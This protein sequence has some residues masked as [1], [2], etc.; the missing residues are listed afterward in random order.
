MR[1]AL[2]AHFWG[3]ETTGSGQY[4]R[5]LVAAFCTHHPDVE[6]A[7]IGDVAAA[8][9]RR[10]TPISTGVTWQTA[11]TPVDRRNRTRA[12]LWFEQVAFPRAARAAGCDLMH[13][14]YFAPPLRRVAALTRSTREQ[15]VIVT[16]HDLI[17]LLLPEYRGR[18]LVRGYSRLVAR[19]SRQADLILAD[20]DASRQDVLRLLHVPSDRVRTVYLGV[21]AR[22]RPQPV[23]EIARVRRKLSL[24]ERFVLYLGGFDVRKQVPM[25]L[26]AARRSQIAWPLVIAGRLPTA[27]TA[28]TPDPRRVAAELDVGERVHYAGWIDENDKPALISAAAIFVFPSRY[29]GFGLPVLE[30]LACGTP[31]ITTT[32]SSLPELA[33]DAALMIAPDDVDGLAAAIDK[34]MRD[35]E[36][37]TRLA[38]RSPV[39]A[40][41]FTWERCAAETAAAYASLVESRP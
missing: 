21:D 34:L 15:P 35:E 32:A 37:R 18:W 25:L 2:N 9:R 8:E 12:K 1:V 14:P 20:S 30:A 27:D 24:P 6:I 41:R 7:L 3:R 23:K 17:P 10:E 26:A 22:Y 4:L 40:A 38:E 31:T 19:S 5:R 11:L 16:V 33:G 36:T 29:E 39:Q 13:V 28:F